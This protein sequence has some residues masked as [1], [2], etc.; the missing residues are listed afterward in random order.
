MDLTRILN[1]TPSEKP[2]ALLDRLQKFLPEIASANSNLS[3]TEEC[4]IKIIPV[5]NES[6]SSSS[7]EDE[8][9]ASS[10]F[11]SSADSDDESETKMKQ[12]EIVMDVTTVMEDPPSRMVIS[13]SDSDVDDDEIQEI[14]PTGFRIKDPVRKKKRKHLM[15]ETD[16]NINN[17]QE[18]LVESKKTDTKAET[19]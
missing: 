9:A 12:P 10:S 16:K 17:N 18:L 1:V 6:D 19:L 8:S 7:F 3:N 4:D 15:E 14:L 2:T 5:E 11:C 13:D